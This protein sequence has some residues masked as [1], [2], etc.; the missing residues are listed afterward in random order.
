[1]LSSIRPPAVAGLFYPADPITLSTELTSYMDQAVQAQHLQV[2][3]KAPKAI[4][5]PHA[6]YIYSGLVAAY[7]FFHI[8]RYKHKIKRVVLLGPAHTVYLQ[9]CA[10][11]ESSHFCTPLG[12][13]PIDRAGAAKLAADDAVTISNIPH[14]EEHSLEVE[15]PFLQHC[16]D[17]FELLPI[18]V[19]EIAPEPMAS[20][21]NLVWGGDETLIVISSDLSHFHPYDEAKRLDQ[22]TCQKILANN[23][24]ISSEQACGC[25][26]LNA[27]SLQ[28]IRHNL[29]ITQLS[30]RNSGDCAASYGADKKRVVGY[31]SFTVS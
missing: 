14:K 15:L 23:S 7:G 21:L 18:L 19:G 9:G 4:I 13:L 25:R 17:E 31:A 16:L 29:D 2:S 20:L 11:P 30:Y 10:L 6:G 3:N 28:L 5:V 1:M 24:D 27:L 26:S 22:D 12:D 8:Q